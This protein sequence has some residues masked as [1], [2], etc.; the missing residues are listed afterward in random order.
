MFNLKE[1]IIILM[2]SL[3]VAFSYFLTGKLA[4]LIAFAYILII[5]LVYI[6]TQKI[7][8][9]YFDVACETKIWTENRFW[10]YEKAYLRTGIPI[11]FVLAFIFPLLSSGYFKW[12]ALTQTDLKVK[13]SR[14]ARK[15]YFYSYTEL[16]EWNISLICGTAIISL[17]ILSILGY[18]FNFPIF[19]RLCIYFALFNL[20]PLGNL[21]GMKI[22]AGSLRYWIFLVVLV[23]LG[24]V[25][26][27]VLP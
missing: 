17:V 14:V 9:Y 6:L 10:L 2:S 8:G 20:L 15:H 13:K 3:L 7:A 26:A 25:A 5:F 22:F 12:L 11:G 23:M 19:S 18:L 4:F 1:I 16:T 24:I 27:V 21:D